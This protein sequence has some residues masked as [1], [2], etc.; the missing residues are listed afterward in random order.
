VPV[1]EFAGQA[2]GEIALRV[3]PTYDFLVRPVA[4]LHDQSGLLIS[5][6]PEEAGWNTLGFSVR[7]LAEGD[8]WKGSSGDHESAILVLGGKRR[9]PVCAYA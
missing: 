8:A 2:I 7:R 4:I 9:S 6:T 3:D 5:V 1:T